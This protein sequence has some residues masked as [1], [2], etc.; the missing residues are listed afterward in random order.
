AGIA[1]HSFL[2]LE[3]QLSAAA[4]LL[5]GSA[6]HAVGWPVAE[7][8]SASITKALAAYLATLGGVVVADRRVQQFTDIPDA[9]AFLFDTSPATL[10]RV[11]ADRLSPG[12]RHSL[13]R[14]RRGPGVFKLD[15]ALDGPVPW[16]AAETLR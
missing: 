9:R 3:H 15:Y 1:A 8:G 5:L 11:A 4:A 10:E 7:S 13:R 2:P 16:R 6:G 12:F 14:H